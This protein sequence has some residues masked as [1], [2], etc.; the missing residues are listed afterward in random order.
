MPDA[1]REV[2]TQTHVTDALMLAFACAVILLY[3]VLERTVE[4]LNKISN[5]ITALTDTASAT[6]TAN[7]AAR[8]RHADTSAA[9][10]SAM[11]RQHQAH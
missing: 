10:Y 6:H 1:I 9:A 8:K 11:L 4:T 3:N 2:L 5:S 7:Q